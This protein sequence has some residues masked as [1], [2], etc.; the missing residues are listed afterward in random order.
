MKYFTKKDSDENILK[1]IDIEF[2]KE[3]AVKTKVKVI[4]SE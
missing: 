2:Q 1:K 3:I 4:D